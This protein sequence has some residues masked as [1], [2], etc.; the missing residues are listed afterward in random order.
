MS[1]RSY[2]SRTRRNGPRFAKLARARIPA[3]NQ[4]AAAVTEIPN[5]PSSVRVGAD[6]S[7]GG[8]PHTSSVNGKG[9]EGDDERYDV[10]MLWDAFPFC[11]RCAAI[12]P[13]RILSPRSSFAD[14]V[15]L[16]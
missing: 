14:I 13:I 1:Q 9:G 12:L 7:C 5:I 6:R 11:H 15:C 2:I 3:F 4:A 16:A 10:I 8:P